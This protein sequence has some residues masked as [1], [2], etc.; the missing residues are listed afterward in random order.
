MEVDKMKYLILGNAVL[1]LLLAIAVVFTFNNL[2]E[3]HN[4]LAWLETI[5][6]G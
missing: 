2:V 6:G 4:Q 5:V 3:I 1:S